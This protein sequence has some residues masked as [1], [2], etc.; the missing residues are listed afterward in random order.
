MRPSSAHDRRDERLAVGG[1]ANVCGNDGGPAALGPDLSGCLLRFLLRSPV[2]Q[3]HI[4]P[5]AGQLAGHDL[6]DTLAARDEH[7]TIHQFHARSDD[8]A[9]PQVSQ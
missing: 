2:R 8:A 9:D 4:G 5:A 1:F 6:A 3:R 7:H